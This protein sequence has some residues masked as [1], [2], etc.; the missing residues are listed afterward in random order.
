MRRV[1]L[2]LPALTGALL[3]GC[4]ASPADT[5]TPA[6]RL[7]R[8]A[9]AGSSIRTRLGTRPPGESA[10]DEAPAAEAKPKKAKASDGEANRGASRSPGASLRFSRAVRLCLRSEPTRTRSR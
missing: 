5:A 4:A 1:A 6:G 10:A 8:A 3:A 2:L 7:R 9:G